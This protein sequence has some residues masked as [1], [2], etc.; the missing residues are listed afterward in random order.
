MRGA[1]IT[2][3]CDCGEVRYL[4]YGDTWECP[5]CGRRW[6]TNQIPADEYWGIMHEMRRFRI[7]AIVTALVI[8]GVFATLF[9]TTGPGAFSLVPL[10][11]GGWF[12]LYMPR[13]RR[14]V[15]ARARGLPTWHLRPE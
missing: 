12:F 6:N 13:W 11:V 8:G 1:L 4:P 15:R 3:K 14:R 2:V 9:A 10:V 5:S 7:Q